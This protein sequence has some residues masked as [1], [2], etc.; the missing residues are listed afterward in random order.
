[1]TGDSAEGPEARGLGFPHYVGTSPG[2]RSLPVT[3]PREGHQPG[4]IVA[5]A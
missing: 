2:C 1:V 4:Y 3:V 5:L